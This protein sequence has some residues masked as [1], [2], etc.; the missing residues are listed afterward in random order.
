MQQ[1]LPPHAL[2]INSSDAHTR[3]VSYTLDLIPKLSATLNSKTRLDVS[4]A[5]AAKLDN[6]KTTPM[7]LR[8]ASSLRR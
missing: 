7:P 6:L 2:P 3:T 1:A 5:L 8:C 4:S